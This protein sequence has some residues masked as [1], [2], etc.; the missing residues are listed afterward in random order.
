MLTTDPADGSPE[1]LLISATWGLAADL[2]AGKMGGDEYWSPRQ[3]ATWSRPGMARKEHLLQAG[4]ACFSKHP[5]AAGID[6]GPGAGG[7]R[8]GAAG[9]LM[10]GY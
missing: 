4:M 5:V 1:N 3:T 6:G 2:V 10:P 8:P 7:G 9:G